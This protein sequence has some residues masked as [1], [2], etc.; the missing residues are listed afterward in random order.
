[1]Q[2]YNSENQLE[3]LAIE[4][5]KAE[6]DE[7]NKDIELTDLKIKIKPENEKSRVRNGKKK[8]EPQV[9]NASKKIQQSQLA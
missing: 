2:N 3:I 1:M 6:D 5:L 4:G 8:S 9:R 7:P